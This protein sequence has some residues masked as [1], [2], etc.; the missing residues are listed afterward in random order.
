MKE[1]FT[2]TF[3]GL[4]S[5][6]GC[7]IQTTDPSPTITDEISSMLDE[8]HISTVEEFDLCIYGKKQEFIQEHGEDAT[9]NPNTILK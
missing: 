9:L 7:E 2:A 6:T 1:I 8:P 5:L 3:W 4:L